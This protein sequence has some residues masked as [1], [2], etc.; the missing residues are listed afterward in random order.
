M[1]FDLLVFFKLYF[2][3]FGKNGRRL[4]AVEQ[5]LEACSRLQ[6]AI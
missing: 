1:N 3:W 5:C 4:I 6:V 2:N